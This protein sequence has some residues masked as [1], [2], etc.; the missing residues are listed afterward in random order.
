MNAM[1]IDIENVRNQEVIDIFGVTPEELPRILMF[2]DDTFVFDEPIDKDTYDFISSVLDSS[3]GVQQDQQSF[4][5]GGDDYDYDN[6]DLYSVGFVAFI[7][8][9]TFY[10]I[11]AYIMY[12][13]VKWMNHMITLIM[14]TIL[15]L[16]MK[17]IIL[18]ALNQNLSK[19]DLQYSLKQYL[20]LK[21]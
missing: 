18:S 10:L 20:G 8:L 9:I 11:I 15:N 3:K 6:F 7:S 21:I 14:A 13:R 4:S 5:F 16:L 1:R 17:K 2:D 12:Y 19:L